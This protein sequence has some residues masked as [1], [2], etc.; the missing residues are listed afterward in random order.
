[1]LGVRRARMTARN[2]RDVL[3]PSI[4]SEEK[5]TP[6]SWNAKVRELRPCD[7]SEDGGVIVQE[8]D[9]VQE[10]GVVCHDLVECFG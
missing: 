8:M 10:L 5:G 1:M 3:R 7:G 2:C 9:D 6:S 4:F